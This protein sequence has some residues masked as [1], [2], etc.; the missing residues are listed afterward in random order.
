MPVRFQADGVAESIVFRR[1]KLSDPVDHPLAHQLFIGEWKGA[2]R[3][4]HAYSWLDIALVA[5]A[6]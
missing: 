2:S 4:S 6:I 3:A 1:A 5:G